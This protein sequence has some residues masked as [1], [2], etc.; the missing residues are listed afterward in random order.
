[1][2]PNR[3]RPPP[4]VV[5]NYNQI[6]TR[7]RTLSSIFMKARLALSTALELPIDDEDREAFVM[8]AKAVLSTVQRMVS[9]DNMALQALVRQYDFGPPTGWTQL[10]LNAILKKEGHE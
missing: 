2:N 7:R 9:N 3:P 8:R 5:A 4:E 10:L 6:I 1:M